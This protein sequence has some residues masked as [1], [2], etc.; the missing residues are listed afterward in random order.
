M[1][2]LAALCEVLPGRVAWGEKELRWPTLAEVFE[3]ADHPKQLEYAESQDTIAPLDIIA[4]PTDTIAAKDTIVPD[5]DIL[6]NS[7]EGIETVVK[8]GEKI[9]RKY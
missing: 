5:R 3:V 4:E 7:S 9:G 2:C 1:A 6:V 8:Y